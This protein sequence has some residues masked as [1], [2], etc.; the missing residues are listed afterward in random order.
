M[1]KAEAGGRVPTDSSAASVC[2]SAL[3]SATGSA[4]GFLEDSVAEPPA[5]SA[6]VSGAEAAAQVVAPSVALIGF[7][8]AG[9]SS[10][11]RALATLLQCRFIDTDA[12]IVERLGPIEEVFAARGEAY[13]REEERRVVADVLEHALQDAAVLA[14][15]GGAVMSKEAHE[16]LRRLPLV[17]WLSA[18]IERLWERAAGVGRPLAQDRERFAELYGEREA[19]Y[20]ALA[21]VTV[22]NDGS[23]S[24]ED[25]A[26]ELAAELDRGIMLR[27]VKA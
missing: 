8:G 14:L 22:V 5:S 9:K 24:V 2:D 11:A 15:G 27:K 19:T 16:G 3:D 23:R 6:A 25:V 13:F 12:L 21:D 18:P 26:Q 17:V 10:V 1:S 20:R 4:T 7:M